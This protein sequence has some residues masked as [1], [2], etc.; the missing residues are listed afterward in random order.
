MRT[1]GAHVFPALCLSCQISQLKSAIIR[2]FIPPKLV[3]ASGLLIFFWRAR[4][5]VHHFPDPVLP[6]PPEGSSRVSAEGTDPADQDPGQPVQQARRLCTRSRGQKPGAVS[7][8]QGCSDSAPRP[9][10]RHRA[11]AGVFGGTVAGTNAKRTAQVPCLLTHRR[12]HARV[13]GRCCRLPAPRVMDRC[14]GLAAGWPHE[15]PAGQGPEV[16]A[17][18]PRPHLTVTRPPCIH[19]LLPSTPGRLGRRLARARSPA[20]APASLAPPTSW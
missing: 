2:I 15:P 14:L 3:H 20:S 7:A 13:G 17:E 8:G 5:I 10:W 9:L 16:D 18:V 12:V 11:P 4:F 1:D 19:A 6:W